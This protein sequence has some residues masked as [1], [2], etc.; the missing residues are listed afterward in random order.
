MIRRM[1]SLDVPRVMEIWLNAT[2]QG[3]PFIAEDY[4]YNNYET[5][6]NQW[7]PAADTYV[8]IRGNEM[9]GFVSVHSGNTIGALF[10]DFEHQGLGIGTALINHV[11][12]VYDTLTLEVYKENL[13]ALRFYKRKGFVV[14]EEKPS[15]N[16]GHMLAVMSWQAGG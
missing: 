7:L 8:D 5:V 13:T 6:K 14:T 2:I 4:W 12:T 9:L 15:D 16:A 10:V 11:K 3:H 1:T